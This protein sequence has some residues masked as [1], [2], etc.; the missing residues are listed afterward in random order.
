MLL[1]S[2]KIKLII[3]ILIA[4]L[5]APMPVKASDIELHSDIYDYCRDN[6]A[7]YGISI[8]IIISIIW[9]ESRG[10]EDAIS[11]NRRYYG[12]MQIDV[13]NPN[14]ENYDLL[15]PAENIRAGCQLLS[16]YIDQYGSIE[17]AL[18]VYQ[19]YGLK[20]AKEGDCS[21]L[22]KMIL[23]NATLIEEELK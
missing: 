7:E 17:T 5:L 4:S 18:D 1:T 12:L 20:Y 14:F 13:K 16:S 10:R 23:R 19:G 22:T 15:D 2:M 8:G 6:K 3:A 9:N 11:E 21:P